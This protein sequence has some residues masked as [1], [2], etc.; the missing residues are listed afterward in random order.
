MIETSL[1]LDRLLANRVAWISVA[2]LAFLQAGF[3]Y[4]PFMQT[5]FGTVAVGGKHWLIPL[6]I[7]FAVFLIVEVEKAVVRNVSCQRK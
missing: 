4:L 6:G 3:V 7:G 1:G 2:A 5:A